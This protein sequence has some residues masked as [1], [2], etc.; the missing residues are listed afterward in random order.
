MSQ[1]DAGMTADFE[2]LPHSV[3]AEQAVLGSILLKPSCLPE[4]EVVLRG[5]YFYIPQHREI[6]NTIVA[7]DTMGGKIDP[8]VILERLKAAKVFDDAGGKKYLADLSL[9]VPSAENALTYA[10]IVKDKFYLRTLIE[11]SREIISESS[12]QESDAETVLENAEQKIYNIRQGRTSTDPTKLEAIIG[13]DVFD[14]LMQIN[15]P[16]AA[17]H[18][19]IS[20][21]YKELDSII[22][23]LNRSD[24]ILL[25]ARPS[26][27]KTSLAL[28]IARNV[29]M[30][31]KKKVLFFSLE[32]TKRQLAERILST[33]ARFPSQKM[34]DGGFTGEDWQKLAEAASTLNECELYFDDSS[35]ITVPEIKARTRRLRNVDC[36][37]IDYL[38]LIRGSKK[39][40]NRVQEVTDIT[41]SL[42][43][44]AKDLNIPVFVCAQLSRNPESRSKSSHRPMLSDLRESG[45][46]EQDADIVLLLHRRDE[47]EAVN[48][49]DPKKMVDIDLIIAKNRHGP[50]DTLEFTM[51][52][53]HTLFLFRENIPDVL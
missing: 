26:V 28:N 19:G 46:I 49:H 39:T 36:V 45:S 33:E 53:E 10:Q 2:N 11:I 31:G 20:T 41:R 30:L 12:V 17:L 43:M 6:F 25:G 14:H 47:D 34:R 1:T 42:K 44:M 21:G 5:D 32:M 35:D 51:D 27:G 23:G 52:K 38:G 18:K 37:F 48:S 24:L 4:I 15:S 22:S 13:Y 7:I 40:E 8:L 16:D 3:H 50:I 9:N 29:A